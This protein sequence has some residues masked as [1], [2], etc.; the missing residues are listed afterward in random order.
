MSSKLTSRGWR[1]L[2]D[3][4]SSGSHEPFYLLHR[5]PHAARSRGDGSLDASAAFESFDDIIPVLCHAL[6][7]SCVTLCHQALLITA[8]MRETCESESFRHVT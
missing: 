6:S 7:P 1:T 2:P 5:W 4:V 3:D 8:V